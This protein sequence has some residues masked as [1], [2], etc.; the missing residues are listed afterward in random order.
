M[1]NKEVQQLACVDYHSK[2]FYIDSTSSYIV[3]TKIAC[4]FD[5]FTL[6]KPMLI[7]F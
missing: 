2:Y 1:R 5:W 7:P 4:D 6:F 3:F